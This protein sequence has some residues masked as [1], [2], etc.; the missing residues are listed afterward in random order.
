MSDAEPV[1]TITCTVNGGLRT[2]TVPVRTSLAD[3]LRETLGLTGTHLGCEEGQ[4]GACTVLSDGRTVRACLLLAVQADGTVIETIEGANTSGR[5]A[6]LQEAFHVRGALQ[7]GFCTS[8][9]LLTADA[10][11]SEGNALERADIRA[12][13]TGHIC[14]CT[15]YQAIVDAIADIGAARSAASD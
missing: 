12:G 14:R 4:C 11:L 3:F 1:R 7:C 15:G 10:M 9:I 2:A 13:L 5:L 6:D 8:G